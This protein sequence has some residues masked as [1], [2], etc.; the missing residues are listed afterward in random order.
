MVKWFQLPFL[1]YVKLVIGKD[2]GY[3]RIYISGEMPGVHKNWSGHC[4]NK[5]AGQ[6]RESGV[7]ILIANIY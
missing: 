7:I 5:I 6:T 3:P 2:M 4:N 1:K